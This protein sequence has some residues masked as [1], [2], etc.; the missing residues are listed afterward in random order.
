MSHQFER[1]GQRLIP[2]RSREAREV[3]GGTA[4]ESGESAGGYTYAGS[5]TAV[6]GGGT[7]TDWHIND[8]W[9]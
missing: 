1:L 4:E 6:P 5:S 2:I 3:L 8:T 7:V 9:D